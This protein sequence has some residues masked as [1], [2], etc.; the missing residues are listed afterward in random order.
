MSYNLD[1]LPPTPGQHGVYTV[2]ALCG[3]HGSAMYDPISLAGGPIEN[4]G[5]P[6]GTHCW[7]MYAPP[8]IIHGDYM[9][10]KQGFEHINDVH[11]TA[12]A[13][14]P[15]TTNLELSKLGEIA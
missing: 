10:V 5:D 12:S 8:I 1:D 3:V 4:A 6:T 11:R 9:S 13:A 14:P 7:L 2:T 15:V